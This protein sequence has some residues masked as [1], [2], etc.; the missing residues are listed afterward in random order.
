MKKMDFKT[1]RLKGL[2]GPFSNGISHRDECDGDAQAAIPDSF[3]KFVRSQVIPTF[4]MHCRNSDGRFS[5]L[6]F[7]HVSS[8]RDVG[9]TSFRQITFNG[10]PLVD[11]SQ[12]TYPEA[13]RYENYVVARSNG[14]EHPEGLIAKEVTALL[15]GFGRA[16]RCYIRNPV[17]TF[18]LLYCSSLPCHACSKK[19]AESLSRVCRKRMVVAYSHEEGTK[20]QIRASI[21]C[22]VDAGISVTKIDKQ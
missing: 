16:E 5:V 21:R 11:S 3:R 18:G 17:P 2:K 13:Y 8:L 12:A 9:R 19:I 4:R 1:R 22:M 6:V 7:S 14:N 15:A 20:E 10:K